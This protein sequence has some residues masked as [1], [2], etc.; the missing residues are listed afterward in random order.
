MVSLADILNARILVVDDQEANVRLLEG[1]LR[2]AGYASIES[3][4]DPREVCELHRKNRYSLILLDLQMPGMDG[5]QVMEG[6]KEIEEDGYLPVLVI[7]AQPAHKLRALEAGAK[8]FVSKPFD[9]AELRARVHNILEV[10]LL[11]LETKNYSKVLEE[12]V[13]E[14]EA[15]REVIRLKT[16]EERKKSEQELALAQETQESLLPRSLPQVENL[17]IHAFNTP[18]RYVGGDFYDFLQLDSG[19]WMGVLADVSGKGMSAA[20]LSSMV[21]GALSMEFHSRTQPQEVLERVNRLLCEK[22]LPYQFV[23][24]FLFVLNP[25][26]MGQ[27]ISAGHTPAYLFHSATGKIEELGSNAN[28]LGLFDDASYESSVFRL[29]KGDIL[30]VYS[31]G[32][33][34]AENPQGEMFGE[35]RLLKLIR[36]EAPSGSQA[37]EQRLLKAI[38]AFTQSLPQTDDITFVVVEKCQ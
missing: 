20:L 29:D 25:Q 9:L 21:L 15:S 7:T 23:T 2:I 30:V 34:D 24:L 13:R 32:L 10:R 37:I 6:L 28:V 8:D 3:T 36:Q 26:G 11:H 33:T 35:E 12:T 17:R 5:F 18:T 38:E 1:M 4:M 14:L 31:D 16:L 19:D 22:S 27:F